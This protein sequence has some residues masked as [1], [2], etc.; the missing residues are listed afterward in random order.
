MFLLAGGR[1]GGLL[2]KSGYRISDQKLGT[3]IGTSN[4]M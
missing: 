4:E 1:G 3:K 2:A